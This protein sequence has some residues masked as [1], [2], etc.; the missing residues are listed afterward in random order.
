MTQNTKMTTQKNLPS[1]ASI[2][3]ILSIVL[4][5]GGFLRIELELNEQKRRINALESVALTSTKS[6]IVSDPDITKSFKYA[7][8]EYA[9]HYFGKF[10][11][12]KRTV[13]GTNSAEFQ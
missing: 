10:N 7:S 3:S 1:F 4:Y 13:W 2:I 8:G 12:V 11:R 6:S 5:C 9:I